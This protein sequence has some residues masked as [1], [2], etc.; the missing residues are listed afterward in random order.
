MG[1]LSKHDLLCKVS[2][3]DLKIEPFKEDQVEPAS[4]DCSLGSILQAGQGR[5][6]FS[7]TSDF[8]LE[9]NSWACVASQEVLTLPNDICARYGIPSSLARRGL[10]AFGGPQIDPG[11]RGKIFVSIYNPT[12][13]PISLRLGQDFFTIIFEEVSGEKHTTYLGSYQD[14]TDFPVSDVEMMMRMRS[15]NLSDVI[16]RV[17]TLDDSVSTLADNME[18]LINNVGE[19]NHDVHALKNTVSKYIPYILMFFAICGAAGL[20][21]VGDYAVN[22]VSSFSTK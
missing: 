22:F 15:K 21:I 11:Y 4:Y 7:E 5:F 13:E 19:I 16:D 2:S 6:D 1:I 3:G 10:I 20:A 12:L 14:Q 17:E 8:V 18:K 9:S